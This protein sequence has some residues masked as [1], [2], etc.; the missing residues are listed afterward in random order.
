M[1]DQ[2]KWVPSAADE[3][4]TPMLAGWVLM[5][6]CDGGK[7]WHSKAVWPHPTSDVVLKA[8]GDCLAQ[9]MRRIANVI[10]RYCLRQEWKTVC[11]PTETANDKR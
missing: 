5:F 11:D 1:S 8:E 2:T 10:D 7:D 9:A 3:I 4:V 6:W